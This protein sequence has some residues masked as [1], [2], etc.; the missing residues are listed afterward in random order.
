MSEIF[1]I[2]CGTFWLD[3]LK[4]IW[5]AKRCPSAGLTLTRP[6]SDKDWWLFP[7]FASAGAPRWGVG[8]LTT[9]KGSQ[10]SDWS[11]GQEQLVWDWVF[12]KD[13]FASE[14]TQALYILSK[15]G[16]TKPSIK[17]HKLKTWVEKCIFSYFFQKNCDFWLKKLKNSDFWLEV[18]QIWWVLHLIGG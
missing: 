18:A 3:Y 15:C 12:I 6:G 7:G 1:S 2:A 17:M 13:F 9:K 4:L 11:A 16:G 8:R 10:S 5:L 14:S